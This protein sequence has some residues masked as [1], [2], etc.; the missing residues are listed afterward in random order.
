MNSEQL[1]LA[2]EILEDREKRKTLISKLTKKYNV[3]CLKANIPGL[4]KNLYYAKLIISHFDKRME[5]TGYFNK[6][7]YKS[8]DG[9][10]VLYTY[11]KNQFDIRY[12]KA[13]M[14]DLEDGEEIGRLVDLD[15]FGSEEVS[16]SRSSSNRRKCLLCD[17]Y[18]V[19][20]ARTQKHSYE[21]LIKKIEEITYNDA[22]KNIEK[23]IDS[24][25]E[26][27]L[28]L[29]YKFGAVCK[30][31]S[32]SHNDMNYQ[33]MHKAKDAIIPY[34]V[35]MFEVGLKTKSLSTIFN[36]IRIIGLEAESAMYKV[37]NGINCYKG[38]IFSLGLIVAS[39]GYDMTHNFDFD[40]IFYNIS[41]MTKNI[42]NDY[43]IYHTYGVD[44]YKEYHFKGAREQAKD[45]L[46]IVKRGYYY[47]TGLKSVDLM[48]T[49]IFIISN[50][51]DTVLLKRAGSIEKYEYVKEMIS[52]IN[53]SLL[54]HDDYNEVIKINEYCINNNLS[55]GGACDMLICTIF[56]KELI[57]R[58]KQCVN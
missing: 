50:I 3:V 44:A 36:K 1:K 11:D 34:F 26:K 37:T 48:K 38:L 23:A 29:P 4:Y 22:K 10:Y 21:E 7:S 43:N 56:L 54:D 30:Y 42:D 45:G 51:D 57:G 6:Y 18:A 41:K 39:M 5:E 12:L 40:S 52:N 49:L 28:E 17:D 35:K 47:N 58:E 31:N 46:K 16:L 53:V 33:L 14:I 13:K 55:T 2:N 19:N 27:E 20:C 8:F 9:P 15:V 32:S 24:A 25:M